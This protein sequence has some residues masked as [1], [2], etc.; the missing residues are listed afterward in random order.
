MI[1]ELYKY[2]LL[3]VT[4]VF[5]VACVKDVEEPSYD[6]AP[7]P[8]I[9]HPM[10]FNV[11]T[12]T[13]VS[14]QNITNETFIIYDYVDGQLYIDGS[15]YH[16]KYSATDD[17]WCFYDKSNVKK[18]FYWT[19]TG[20]HEFFAFNEVDIYNYGKITITFSYNSDK[21][22]LTFSNY[23]DLSANKYADLIYG[24]V[25]RNMSDAN[26]YATVNLN[27]SHAFA[28][29]LTEFKNEYPTDVV[30]NSFSLGTIKYVA[31][32]QP[33]IQ[34]DSGLVHTL[35]TTTGSYTSGEFTVPA[36]GTYKS[37]GGEIMIWP[38]GWYGSGPE[39]SYTINDKDQASKYLSGLGIW[40]IS[41]GNLYHNVIKLTPLI[42]DVHV[43]DL[44]REYVGNTI[45]SNLKMVLKTKENNDLSNND[46]SEISNLII[47][48]SQGADVYH[49]YAP[50]NLSSSEIV[51]EGGKDMKEGLYTVNWT[52]EDG[53]GYQ[54]SYTTDYM[55]PQIEEPEKPSVEPALG[56]YINSDGSFSETFVKDLSIAKIFWMG[57]PTASDPELKAKFPNCS[58]GL[59]YRV[60]NNGNCSFSSGKFP[61]SLYPISPSLMDSNITDA[62]TIRGYSNTLAIISYISDATF[63]NILGDCLTSVVDGVTSPWYIPSFEEFEIAFN[64]DKVKPTN[65]TNAWVSTLYSHYGNYYAAVCQYYNNNN[66][67]KT[68]WAPTINNPYPCL[69]ILAF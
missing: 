50:L 63:V 56:Y 57:D 31:E 15:Q 68:N 7:V 11:G 33:Y 29:M 2:L 16:L 55:A 21:S 54:Y 4:A 47:T 5:A 38:Q 69:F 28:S 24:Y 60:D 3:L 25:T 58:H 34:F 14:N 41:A 27:L 12:M 66:A 62:A 53:I 35:N 6:D 30:V 65:Q 46:L 45:L 19:E 49:Q 10:R 51:S 1:K 36:G 8:D 59:A 9:N 18:D 67:I 52:Y 23:F 13:K 39:L 61:S 64:K 40:Q 22:R 37:F 43:T 32:G 20:T 26:P 48:V 17:G 44:E 42:F